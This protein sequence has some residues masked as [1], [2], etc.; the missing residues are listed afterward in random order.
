L[1]L[2]QEAEALEAAPLFGGDKAAVGRA[3]QNADGA[4]RLRPVFLKRR[5]LALGGDAQVIGVT[6]KTAVEG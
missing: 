3:A 4:R 2:P 5:R 6:L 1:C